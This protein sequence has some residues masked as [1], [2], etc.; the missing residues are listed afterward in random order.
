M[1]LTENGRKWHACNMRTSTQ[2]TDC[3][4]EEGSQF[5]FRNWEQPID[6]TSNVND[7]PV[8][9]NVSP[10]DFLDHSTTPFKI[11]GTND[12]KLWSEITSYISGSFTDPT[13][14]GK[15]GFRSHL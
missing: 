2:E 8:W 13:V 14:N 5:K 1:A 3:P 6:A 10:D 11:A 15:Q 12:T 7:T 9:I 4:L